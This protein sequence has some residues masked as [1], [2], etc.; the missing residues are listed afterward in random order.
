MEVA[1]EGNREAGSHHARDRW[2]GSL[3]RCGNISSAKSDKGRT[4]RALYGRP[5]GKA[6]PSGDETRVWAERASGPDRGL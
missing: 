3:Y 6:K 4:S 5:G 1:P 2:P